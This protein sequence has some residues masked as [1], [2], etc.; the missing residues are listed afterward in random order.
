MTAFLL[1]SRSLTVPLFVTEKDGCTACSAELRKD[2]R[3]AV[4]V[5]GRQVR[6]SWR[7]VTSWN[8]TPRP[9]KGGTTASR[10]GAMM[11]PHAMR[12]DRLRVGYGSRRMT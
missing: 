6:A 11:R 7:V 5:N 8:A 2:V 12:A 3:H 4:S 10:R 9:M 1:C